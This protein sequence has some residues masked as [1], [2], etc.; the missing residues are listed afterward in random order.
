M[1]AVRA[2]VRAG[3]RRQPRPRVRQGRH[4]GA[5]RVRRRVQR[6]VDPDAHDLPRAG[7]RVL[8][9]GRAARAGAREPDRAGT[10]ARHGGRARGDREAKVRGA[11]RVACRDASP[12]RRHLL[13][14]PLA[15]AD[16]VGRAARRRERARADRRRRSAEDVLAAG[17]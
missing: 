3:R 2:R 14:A 5:A 16:R 15:R 1:P 10:G 12:S 13:Q 8:A 6:D 4:R 11:H 17:E 9:A 7:A